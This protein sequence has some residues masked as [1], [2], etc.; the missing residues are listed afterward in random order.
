MSKAAMAWVDSPLR[1][2][3]A[4][5]QTQLGPDLADVVGVLAD[6]VRR[7][8]LGVGVLAGAAGAL[9]VA[10]PDALVALLG[11][12]LG[13]QEGDLGH[14]LLPAGEH[15][16]VADRGGQR[17][18]DGGELHRPDPVD[19]GSARSQGLC[20][21]SAGR[22]DGNGMSRTGGHV[23]L[24]FAEMRGRAPAP[25]ERAAGVDQGLEGVAVV[26]LVD[27]HGGDHTAV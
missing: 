6:Q 21:D 26:P 2:T 25:L 14:R 5:A 23:Q 12:D 15:L 20:R 16:G 11:G 17:Q 7:D 3:E 13:E 8:L 24:L 9:G 22:W 4:P 27:V 19:R 10:E 18:G 1:P